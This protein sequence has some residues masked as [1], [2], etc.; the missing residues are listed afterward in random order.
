MGPAMVPR[1]GGRW[2]SGA[3]TALGVALA[4]AVMVLA[5]VGAEV[6]AG[7]PV[8]WFK[9]AAAVAMVVVVALLRWLAR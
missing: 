9:R 1:D 6:I 8:S 7:G 5:W 4:S 3:G 2:S